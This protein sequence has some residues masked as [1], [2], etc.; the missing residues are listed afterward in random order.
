MLLLCKRNEACKATGQRQAAL[1]AREGS[2]GTHRLHRGPAGRSPLAAGPGVDPRCPRT[3]RRNRVLRRVTER[4]P[5]PHV[6]SSSPAAPEIAGTAAGPG[7][8][9]PLRRGWGGCPFVKTPF[10]WQRARS[11]M[12]ANFTENREK[13]K[14]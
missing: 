11:V 8:G 5:S 14:P 3:A 12:Q 2:G 9:S 7:S 10:N 4:P 6:P 13:R 1:P